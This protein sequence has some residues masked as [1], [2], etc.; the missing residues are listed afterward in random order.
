MFPAGFA[1][2]ML[3]S[4]YLCFRTMVLNHSSYQLFSVARR[5]GA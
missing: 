5:R 4:G 3:L 1:A 2:K